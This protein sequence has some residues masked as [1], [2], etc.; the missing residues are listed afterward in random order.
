[1]HGRWELLLEPIV[2]TKEKVSQ[3]N[4]TKHTFFLKN[5]QS[6]LLVITDHFSKVNNLHP[7]VKERL[8]VI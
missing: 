4:L 1:M 8:N 6:T 2:E 3:P 7:Q 5:L